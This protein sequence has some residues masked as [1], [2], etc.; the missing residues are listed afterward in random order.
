MIHF[1]FILARARA[2]QTNHK[3]N[4]MDAWIDKRNYLIRLI[5]EVSEENGGDDPGWLKDYASEM[6]KN[7]GCDLDVPIT[8][9]ESLVRKESICGINHGNRLRPGGKP[10]GRW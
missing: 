7:Y 1:F 6:I 9:F 8:C 2:N 10:M 3:D 5:K 4:K